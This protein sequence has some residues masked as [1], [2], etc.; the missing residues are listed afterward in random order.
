MPTALITGAT[1]G[2]GAAFARRLAAEHYDLVL[3]ARTTERLERSA[4]EL[5]EKYGVAVE[6]LTADLGDPAELAKVEQRV[7]DDT[8]PVDL[9]VNNA[10]FGTQ[11][12]FPTVDRNQLQNQLDVNVGAVLRLT[13]AVVPGM[14]GR[15]RGDVINVSSVAGFL[16][17]GGPAYAATK[18]YVTALSEGL[19]ANL[20]AKGVRVLA[21]CPGFV[22]TE[23]HDRTGDDKS[24]IPARLWMQADRVVADALAD[25]R[26]NKPVSVPGRQ[27]KAMVFALR[28]APRPLLRAIGTRLATRRG[29]T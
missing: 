28:Y 26:R 11:G 14:V 15:G 6:V 12:T 29:R 4:A 10:G 2:L 25:L 13:H 8:K 7:A 5:R 20:A 16:P 3:V 1:A 18:A 24:K 17:T 21:L 23:F 22:H 19:H 27:Y 9:L